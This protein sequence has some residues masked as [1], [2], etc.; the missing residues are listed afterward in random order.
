MNP[1]KSIFVVHEGKLLGYIISK[2]DISIDL[3]RI[4]TI[5]A[6][7]L[8]RHKKGLASFI[9]R[10][11]FIKRFIP[12]IATLMQP[13]TTILKKNIPFQWT[14]EGKNDFKEIKE[15]IAVAPTLINPNFEKDFILYG[16][17]SEDTISA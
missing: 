14:K 17:G 13:L 15:A 12:N 4:T 11:N 6:L 8:P 5:L 16:Y 3:E 7:P 1:K 10:I 9:G 2:H